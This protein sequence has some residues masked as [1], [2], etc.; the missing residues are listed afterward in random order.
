MIRESAASLLPGDPRTKNLPTHVDNTSETRSTAP[1]Y[2]EDRHHKSYRT[3]RSSRADVPAAFRHQTIS[4]AAS[5]SASII[6]PSNPLVTMKDA[7]VFPS[8]KNRDGNKKDLT[9]NILRS[10]LRL[11][12]SGHL[13]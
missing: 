2:N 1:I 5:Y 8:L 12:R 11:R 3:T 7:D 6:T 13:Q 9:G 4:E 10:S